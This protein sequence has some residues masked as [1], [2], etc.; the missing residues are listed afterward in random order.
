MRV[1]DSEV[2]TLWFWKLLWLRERKSW[3]NTALEGIRTMSLAELTASAH[4]RAEVPG[5]AC[6]GAGSRSLHD[7]AAVELLR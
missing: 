5:R 3:A 1:S 7:R 4:C 6:Q 2:L